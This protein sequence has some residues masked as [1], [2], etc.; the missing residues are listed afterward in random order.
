MVRLQKYW[1]SCKERR[2]FFSK[3]TSAHLLSDSST[4]VRRHKNQSHP[5]A[6]AP[7]TA[8]PSAA[9]LPRPLAAVRATVLLRVFSEIASMNFSTPLAYG[10]MQA[11]RW[12]GTLEQKKAAQQ[13]VLTWSMVLQQS[14]NT[15][16]GWVSWRD[17]FRSLS[18]CSRGD[19]PSS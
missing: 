5:K 13:V 15:P 16:T 7:A 9:D 18:S 4:F 6:T 2:W 1:N 10:R 14:T 11:F 19:K 12:I 3:S 17:S 8:S